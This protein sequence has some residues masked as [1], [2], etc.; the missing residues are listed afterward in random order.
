MGETMSHRKFV[1]AAGLLL[2]SIA[3]VSAGDG[4]ELKVEDLGLTSAEAVSVSREQAREILAEARKAFATI[5]NDLGTGS[6]EIF[7]LGGERPLWAKWDPRSEARIW[8]H[9]EAR[10]KTD[11]L[12]SDAY[13]ERMQRGDFRIY[14]PAPVGEGLSADDRHRIWREMTY[15]VISH[16]VWVSAPI[17]F[18]EGLAEYY[19][20]DAAEGEHSL[21]SILEDELKQGDLPVDQVLKASSRELWARSAGRAVSWA[22]VTLLMR[23]DDRILKSLHLQS[24]LLLDHLV[25]APDAATVRR[26]F[27][28]I[29]VE[30]L[31]AMGVSSSDLKDAIKLWVESGF[32]EGREFRQ[33][34]IKRI[35]KI[36]KSPRPFGVAMSGRFGSRTHLPDDQNVLHTYQPFERGIVEWRLPWQATLEVFVG[37]R[38][39]PGKNP[40]LRPSRQS[41]GYFYAY[42]PLEVARSGRSG[43]ESISLDLTRQTTRVGFIWCAISSPNGVGYMFKQEYKLK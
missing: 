29:F 35:L 21:V 18:L 31:G 43:L 10:V 4:M 24:R 20:S 3:S 19:G 14:L 42:P 2:L 7:A 39:E 23:S 22:I 17:W 41:D 16:T 1:L 26:E 37:V 13:L 34:R 36:R 25:Q 15:A 8:I 12:G 40:A 11:S 32:A 27:S 5:A 38:G 9:L 6:S 28:D 33:L 30:Q